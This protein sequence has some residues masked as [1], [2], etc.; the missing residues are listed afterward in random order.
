LQKKR[1]ELK[2]PI[3][4]ASTEIHVPSFPLLNCELKRLQ[5]IVMKGRMKIV[6]K[7]SDV[8]N[9]I[10]DCDFDNKRLTSN[11]GITLLIANS[12]AVIL[13]FKALADEAPETLY[14]QRLDMPLL[15]AIAMVGATVGGLLARERKKELVRLNDQL[16]QINSTLR[17]QAK[18]ESYAPNLRYAPAN[19]IIPQEEVIVDPMKEQLIGNLRTGKKYLRSREPDKAFV[20][21][22]TAFDLADNLGDQIEKK[23]AAR[24]LGASLQRQGKYREAIEYHSKVLEIAQIANDD[25]GT[26]E[27]HGA[28]ADCYTELGDLEKAAKFYDNYIARLKVD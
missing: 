21:F 8:Y 6:K 10:W 15:F 19:R 23:K 11:F 13:P 18:I 9:F 7:F 12:S 25:S 24:G 17:R 1:I 28:I 14:P 3:L 16:R 2:M 5:M 4:L 26:T 22:K 20:E 27:A